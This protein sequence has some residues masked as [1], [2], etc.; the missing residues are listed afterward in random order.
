MIGEEVIIDGLCLAVRHA[1]DGRPFLFIHGLCGDA[2]QTLEVFPQ[3]ADWRC[4]S[5]ECRGHGGSEFGDSTALSI[6]QFTEDMVEL[7]RRLDGNAPV[8]GGIS[9]GAAIALRAAALHPAMFSGLV[10]ARP[11]WVDQPAPD[12]LAPHRMIADDLATLGAEAARQKFETSD[13]ARQVAEQAP[14]NMTSYHGFFERQPIDQT[15][16]LLAAIARDGPG[17]GRHDI[18]TI[19]IPTLVIGT[20]RDLAH[21]LEMAKTL[22]TLIPPARL[23][24]ITPKSDNRQSYVTEFRAAISAFLKEIG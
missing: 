19:D 3:I 14:D 5:P 20:A 11:A 24:E 1:G 6:A 18:A 23:A 22:A 2:G 9:M 8:I 15:Q 21:P 12:N 17:V 13:M 16:A 7:A 4:I 10:L